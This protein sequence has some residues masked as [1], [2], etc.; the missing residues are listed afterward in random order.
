MTFIDQPT[1][2][3][4]MAAILVLTVGTCSAGFGLLMVA[5]SPRARANPGDA[6]V[7]F[8]LVAFLAGMHLVQADAWG[9]GTA[10]AIS[11]LRLL[12]A[13]VHHVDERHNPTRS[14][15]SIMRE[16]SRNAHRRVRDRRIVEET[17]RRY[18]ADLRRRTSSTDSADEPIELRP[19]RRPET[20]RKAPALLEAPASLDRFEAEI[21][22]AI[23]A[24]FEEVEIEDEDEAP[25][26][27]DDGEIL[28][29][30]A[31][32]ID[33]DDLFRRPDRARSAMEAIIRQLGEGARI[34]GIRARKD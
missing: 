18:E 23:D 12:F 31:T 21:M 27:P 14:R 7:A 25:G 16:K 6:L 29:R 2:V 8:G 33:A 11:T 24:E 34:V 10:V 30:F 20:E 26:A 17:I 4:A 32:P 3:E 28:V 19:H 5:A 9:I 22:D 1:E 13:T 15:E